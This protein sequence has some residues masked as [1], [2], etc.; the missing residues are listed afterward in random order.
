MVKRLGA[1]RAAE[2]LGVSK[3]TF[4]RML[5]G[6]TLIEPPKVVLRWEPGFE[7][8]MRERKKGEKAASEDAINST[9]S[10]PLQKLK[11]SHT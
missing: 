3:R 2:A 5:R 1:S 10:T 11:Y 9:E 6:E 8:F 4:Y 7:E